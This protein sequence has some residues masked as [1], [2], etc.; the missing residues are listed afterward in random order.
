MTKQ[1]ILDKLAANRHEF[2]R[3]GVRSLALFGSA[4]REEASE[5]SDIDLLVAF[6]RPVGLFGLSE[7]K[8]VLE[9][10]LGVENVDL[11]TR[12]GLH[13][14]LKERILS[15]AVDAL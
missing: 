8:R 3:H 11:I 13:P 1:Q 10:L 7:L 15:E 2:Q 14:A 9:Q 4:A 6:D 12:E 5:M